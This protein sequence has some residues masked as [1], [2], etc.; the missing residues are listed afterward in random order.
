MKP[1]TLKKRHDF[2]RVRGGARYQGPAF[3]LEAKRRDAADIGTPNA[4]AVAFQG[5]RFGFTV[6]KRLG[7]AVK[8]NRIRRRLKAAIGLTAEAGAQARTDYVVVA[9]AAA[10]DVAFADLVEQF[11]KA[12]EVTARRTTAGGGHRGGHRSGRRG[13]HVAGNQPPDPTNTGADRHSRSTVTR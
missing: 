2:L 13:R 11:A 9:R 3:L 8:R 5:P 4:A 10:Y 6:T 12:F 7:G 1:V